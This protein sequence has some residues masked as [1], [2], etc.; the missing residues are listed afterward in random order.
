MTSNITRSLLLVVLT[1]LFLA[2]V[3][4]V[5][6]RDDS[7]LNHKLDSLLSFGRYKSNP[8]TTIAFKEKKQAADICPYIQPDL[9]ADWQD[10]KAAYNVK[11]A[12]F[13][14]WNIDSYLFTYMH[15]KAL[16]SA[17]VSYPEASFTLL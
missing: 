8:N 6:R 16:E 12:I 5:H 2:I 9:K 3:N 14:D 15:Y 4:E 10:E 11:D 17:F 1:F 13:L 7:T